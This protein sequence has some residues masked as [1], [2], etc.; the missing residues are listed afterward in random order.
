MMFIVTVEYIPVMSLTNLKIALK[1][2]FV[3]GI[4]GSYLLLK[5]EPISQVWSDILHLFRAPD[6]Y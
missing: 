5:I 6:N 2:S 3:S 1:T 4:K